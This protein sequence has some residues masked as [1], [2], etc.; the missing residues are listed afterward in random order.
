MTHIPSE[1]DL[2]E[3]ALLLRRLGIDTRPPFTP[4]QDCGL[5]NSCRGVRSCARGRAK[6]ACPPCNDD[7]NQ[8]RACSA[9]TQA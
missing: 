8:G 4:C 6:P 2:A 7:C 5:P 3:Q 9:R 1:S